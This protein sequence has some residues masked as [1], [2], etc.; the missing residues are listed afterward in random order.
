MKMLSEAAFRRI[1]FYCIG[2]LERETASR[3]FRQEAVD[4]EPEEAK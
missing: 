2:G 4:A 3:M 1:A